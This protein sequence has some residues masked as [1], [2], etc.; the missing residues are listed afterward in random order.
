MIMYMN[1]AA[2]PP[3]VAPPTG[4][5]FAPWMN[6]C[7]LISLGHTLADEEQR[8]ALGD[9]GTM[10]S[11]RRAGDVA[12]ITIED[13]YLC[14]TRTPLMELIGTPT[15]GELTD[16]IDSAACDRSVRGILLSLTIDGGTIDGLERAGL[17]VAAATAA[18][19]VYVHS[20][21][22]LFGAGLFL[23][24]HATRVYASSFAP[25]GGLRV[26]HHDAMEQDDSQRLRL[27]S[28][29]ACERRL[30]PAAAKHVAS[31]PVL[32]LDGQRCRAR[33]A[34]KLGLIDDVVDGIGVDGE[35]EVLAALRERIGGAR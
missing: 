28:I 32:D 4:F 8:V 12:I 24:A 14:S 22:G 6:V 19:P 18:K 1:A 31:G 17:S 2:T 27:T 11:T 29:I 7:H 20:P 13:G 33:H 30:T 5:W 21:G 34:R 15:Y 25:V 26:W 16:A 23:A 9:I 3:T 10:L 35:A